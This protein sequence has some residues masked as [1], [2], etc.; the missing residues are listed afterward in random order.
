MPARYRVSEQDYVNAMRLHAKP[1]PRYLW[2]AAAILLVAIALALW[3]PPLARAGA[4]GGMVGGIAVMLASFITIPWMA[5][6]HYRK[7]K[8]IHDEFTVELL[9][10][11]VRFASSHADGKLVWANVLKWRQNDEF[12]LLYP[13]PRIFH[14]IPKSI[15]SQGFD[16]AALIERLQGH[17]GAAR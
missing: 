9:E 1:T 7:Y 17:V 2:T 15:A 8:A 10:D 16:I 12:V 13:M 6:R 11:G 3:G 4:I 5:R 14:I